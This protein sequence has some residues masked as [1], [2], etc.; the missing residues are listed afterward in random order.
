MAN[1]EVNKQEHTCCDVP[2]SEEASICKECGNKGKSVK[3]ST[4]KSIVKESSFK[5]INNSHGFYFCETPSC[6]VV[7][8]NN[9]YPIYLYKDDVKIRVGIKETEDPIPV[10]YCFGWTEERIFHEIRQSGY[11]TAIQEISAKVN[12]G[13]CA[14][15]INNPSGRCCL[16]EVNKVVKRGM[17]LH[18]K[19]KKDGQKG[20]KLRNLPIIGSIIAAIVA[21]L[22]CIGPVV[23]AI[24]GVGGASLF[25][26]FG[27]FRLYSIGIT[28]VLLGLG[29]YLTYRKREV[30]CEDGTCKIKSAGK[31][32]RIALWSATILVVFFVAFPY[33]NLSNQNPTSN[34]I[35]MEIV[36]TM[37][38]V[39]GMTCSGC[40]FNVENA[41]KKLGGIVQV[42]ADYQKGEV[43]IKYEKWQV[44]VDSIIDAINKAGYKATKS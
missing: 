39:E 29:F 24:L 14:C 32:N 40:E 15:E 2:A 28:F 30:I 35:K 19:N 21:S 17:G 20:E 42:K 10:C 26:K 22:C 9:E 6:K 25:P 33:L 36:E 5:T 12:A 37:I 38:P 13:E 8:F 27:N 11:S 4:L 23:L 31:W 34:Q 44:T 43:Y 41:V 7:Y 3:G 1:E 16:G 18:G